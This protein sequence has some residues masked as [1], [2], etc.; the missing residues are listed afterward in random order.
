MSLSALPANAN[1]ISCRTRN[2][3]DHTSHIYAVRGAKEEKKKK[4]GGVKCL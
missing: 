4:Q 2:S 3:R 1:H